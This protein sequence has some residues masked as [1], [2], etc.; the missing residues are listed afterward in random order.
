MLNLRELKV[1]IL[2]YYSPNLARYRDLGKGVLVQVMPVLIAYKSL[3]F[4]ENQ[5]GYTYYTKYLTAEERQRLWKSNIYIRFGPTYTSVPPPKDTL[6][7]NVN[8]KREQYLLLEEIFD[9]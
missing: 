6:L 8:S 3:V 2:F 9:K 5:H 1:N 4:E 7:E